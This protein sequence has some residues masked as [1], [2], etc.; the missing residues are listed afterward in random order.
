MNFSQGNNTGNVVGGHRGTKKVSTRVLAPPGGASS[1][2]IGNQFSNTPGIP[3]PYQRNTHQQQQQQQQQHYTQTGAALTRAEQLEQ[4]K[5]RATQ[6]DKRPSDARQRGTSTGGGGSSFNPFAHS[7]QGSYSN[8]YTDRNSRGATVSATTVASE[9]DLAFI[10]GGPKYEVPASHN[11]QYGVTTTARGGSGNGSSTSRSASGSSGPLKIGAQ[12]ATRFAKSGARLASA[13][14]INS[15]GV[16]G[17]TSPGGSSGGNGGATSS[18][19]RP[20]P[21]SMNQA[22]GSNSGRGNVYAEADK[23]YELMKAMSPTNQSRASNSNPFG[24]GGGAS[25]G[26]PSMNAMMSGRGN[27][28]QSGGQSMSKRDMVYEEKRRKRMAQGGGGGGGG[29]GQ[30]PP[31]QQQQQQ[32]QQQRAAATQRLAQIEREQT[33]LRQQHETRQLEEMQ[34]QQEHTQR[35][36]SLGQ[37]QPPQQ[38]QQQQQ[39]QQYMQQQQQ[40]RQQAP[41][42][43]QYMQ[44]PQQQVQNLTMQQSEMQRQH[45]QQSYSQ[46]CDNRAKGNGQLDGSANQYGQGGSVDQNNGNVMTGR[47]TTRRLAPPG[48]FSSFS[49]G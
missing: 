2:S 42:P 17:S 4:Q 29:Y 27:G 7:G 5:F 36:Q 31:Q 39:Q 15:G 38:Q 22:I 13:S 12:R 8:P 21:M 47:S 26:R 14:Q 18:S 43:Q 6:A 46:I 34:R 3:D 33:L 45:Q 32:Q 37:H 19:R 48:G 41:P 30:P 28:G 20:P 23:A 44:Q 35:M 25:P 1:W 16:F 49:L 10:G 9:A 24:S 40:M 11:P